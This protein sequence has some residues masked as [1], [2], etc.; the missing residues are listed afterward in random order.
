MPDDQTRQF[1]RARPD[2]SHLQLAMEGGQLGI[3]EL[4]PATLRFRWSDNSPEI[5]GWAPDDL[6]ETL[7]DL[8]DRIVEEDR[9]EPMRRL[10]ELLE[11]QTEVDRAEFRI[12]HRDGGTRW[13][14]ARGRLVETPSGEPIATGTFHNISD[15]KQAELELRASEERLRV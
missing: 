1:D 9:N 8:L 6:P 12:L 2:L 4:E 3:W 7:H 14:E 15:R 10:T 11:G 5:L 13:L